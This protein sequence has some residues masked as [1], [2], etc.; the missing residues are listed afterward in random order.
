M[1]GRHNILLFGPP[2]AGKSLLAKVANELQPP[3]SHSESI[4][5]TK[6]HSL[7]N[8]I[9]AIVRNRPYRSPHHSISRAAMIGDSS[10]HPGEISL[11]HNGILFLDELPEFKRDVLESLRQ[12]LEDKKVSIGSA[13]QRAVFPA[14]FMLIAT[15]N[16]CPCGYLGSNTH[17]CHCTMSQIKNYRHRISGPLLDRIDLH[18]KVS[19]VN[20]SVL[21]KN[22]TVSTHEHITAKNLIRDTLDTQFK[23]YGKPCADLNSAETIQYCKPSHDASLFLND[24][25]VK[26]GLSARAYF[27]MLKLSRTIADIEQSETV[28]INHVA[29]ALQYRS[30][31]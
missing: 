14:N 27:K 30:I 19:T 15:M 3:L 7:S 18:I 4:S 8:N 1:S 22:T 12:P 9:F 10:A 17:A 11:A 25:S 2:G 26:L 6:I 16:P 13:R 24:A 23:R 21:L 28:T 31:I 20:S 5:T 29:E